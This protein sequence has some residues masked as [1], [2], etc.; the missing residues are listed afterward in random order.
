MNSTICNQ[1]LDKSLKW[2]AIYTRSRHEF[3]V[4]QELA[5][6][7]FDTFLPA[8]KS[9]RRWKDRKK[10]INIPLFP[11]YLFLHCQMDDHKY[12]EI[13][14]TNGVVKVL[15][16][17]KRELFSIPDEEIESVRI[18]TEN[19]TT[20]K[21]HPY[22]KEENSIE[23]VNGP[24]AGTKGILTEKDSHKSTIVV[25]IHLIVKSI[26]CEVDNSDIEPC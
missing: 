25:T 12:L 5:R 15:G 10:Y 24:L 7:Q 14:K 1:E 2:Y 23:I 17:N 3:K 9:L 4:N 18:L 20:I 8:V 13:Q 19:K 21:H 26:S 16:K 22:V 11:G 6:K